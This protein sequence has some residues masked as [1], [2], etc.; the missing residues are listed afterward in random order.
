MALNSNIVIPAFP[1]Q[2]IYKDRLIEGD[3][4]DYSIDFSPWS[5]ENNNINSVTWDVVSG[6]AS[7][8]NEALSSN[9][10]TAVI[11]VSQQGRN[12]IQVKAVGTTS[13]K[14]IWLDI[15]VEDPNSGFVS[16]YR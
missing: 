2:Q 4:Q 6:N 5:E 16:D 3:I 12:L 10:A 11:N 1:K 7:L 15:F 13:T 8:S 14:V 9:I